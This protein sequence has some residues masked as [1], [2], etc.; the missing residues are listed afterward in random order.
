MFSRRKPK[1]VKADDF[2][3]KKFAAK[4]EKYFKEAQPDEWASYIAEAK[5]KGLK[6]PW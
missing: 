4:I 6:G 1:E 2:I 3:D 5:A